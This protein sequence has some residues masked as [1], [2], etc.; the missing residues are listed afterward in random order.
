MAGLSWNARV[1]VLV[2]VAVVSLAGLF[3]FVPAIP[4]DQAFHDLADKRAILGIPNFWNVVSNLP[5]FVIGIL[6]MRLPGPLTQRMFFFG[7]FLVTFGSSY[8]HWAPSDTP[9]MWDRLPITLAFMAILA[10][11]LEERVD[12]SAGRLLLWPLLALGIASLIIWR[13]TDDLRLYG[14]VVFFPLLVLPLLFWLFPSKYT[15][16]ANWFIAAGLY[17]ASKL[18]EVTDWQIMSPGGIVS[19]HTLKH[20]FVAAAAYVIYRNFATRKKFPDAQR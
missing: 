10:N 16:T 20:L 4:Q 1:L 18:T 14:W 2:A 11:L 19:G 3:L 6:G 15:G 17:A 7:I 12:E 9:L 5:F 8:Y 13:M